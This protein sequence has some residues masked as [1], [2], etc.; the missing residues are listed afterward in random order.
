MIA[1]TSACPSQIARADFSSR[2]ALHR[3]DLVANRRLAIRKK[4]LVRRARIRLGAVK[5]EK[6]LIAKVCDSESVQRLSARHERLA[7]TL[8]LLE[9]SRHEQKKRLRFGRF[10]QFDFHRHRYRARFSLRFPHASLYPRHR[11]LARSHIGA[12]TLL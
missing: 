2:A 9:R 6:I 11:R 5:D 4:N 8:P 1:H 3:P 7:I 12:S 10:L